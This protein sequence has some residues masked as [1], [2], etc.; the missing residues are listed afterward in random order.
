MF[1]RLEKANNIRKK[2][3]DIQSEGD[4]KKEKKK[5]E[6]LNENFKAAVA[7]DDNV[8]KRIEVEIDYKK[9]G[10]SHVEMDALL[11]GLDKVKPKSKVFLII[12]VAI[13]L[14]L[15]VYFIVRNVSFIKDNIIP[16]LFF[17]ENKVTE[18]IILV[19]D[20]NRDSEEAFLEFKDSVV[21][22][23]CQAELKYGYKNDIK[24]SVLCINYEKQQSHLL[25][26]STMLLIDNFSIGD[27]K[28]I[29]FS[30][31]GISQ[32]SEPL[33]LKVVLYSGLYRVEAMVG[34]L[35]NYWKDYKI[36]LSDFQGLDKYSFISEVSF[37]INEG[38]ESF[39]SWDVCVD[40]IKL[41]K[42]EQR[43]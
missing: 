41:I 3:Q 40:D 6:I 9:D 25:A 38:D 7:K 31:K 33:T 26:P 5:K 19:D 4:S 1:K 32:S 12:P 2:Q 15:L 21:A 13:V 17:A 35:A 28:A 29:S 27:V 16:K 10:V 22:K 18:E 34:E 8:E 14:V 11:D 37:V 43:K 24:D 39:N 42:K 30:M 20:F 23:Y 36:F